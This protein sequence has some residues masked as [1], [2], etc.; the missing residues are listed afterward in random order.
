MLTVATFD[1]STGAPP[2][3][4]SP[5]IG[6]H[7]VVRPIHVAEN[8]PLFDEWS[9]G[10]DGDPAKERTWANLP[11]QPEGPEAY[12]RLANAFAV[13]L[14]SPG[15]PLIY[16]GDEYG[17]AGGGDPDNRRMLFF[18]DG[19]PRGAVRSCHQLA[20]FERVKKL[21]AI[22]RAYANE[23]MS[24]PRG[25]ALLLLVALLLLCNS[26]LKRTERSDEAG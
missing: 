1:P 5:W 3:V 7:D 16:Y 11:R 20:L 9:N 13:L 2:P 25:A 6:N 24:L 23:A 15:A 21:A 4:M 12:E 26:L 14:T 22:R 17:L 8:D 18:T 19:T 10:K